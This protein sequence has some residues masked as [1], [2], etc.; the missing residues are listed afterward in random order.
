MCSGSARGRPPSAPRRRTSSSPARRAIEQQRAAD[1]IDRTRARTDKS[2]R[3]LIS[4][5][6]PE[7]A[8]Q[9]TSSEV[10]VVPMRE[11]A[12]VPLHLLRIAIL[13]VC[14]CW[15]AN[16]P[17][18]S[19]IGACPQT[20]SDDIA[21]APPEHVGMRSGRLAEAIKSLRDKSRD[22]H[23]L[24]VWRNCRMVIELYAESVTRDHNHAVYSVTKSVLATLFG[25]LLKS[26]RLPS[27]DATVADIVAASAALDADKLEKARRIRIRHAMSMASGLD[28][29]NDPAR[30]PIY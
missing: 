11:V 17:A 2:G 3:A 1:K 16:R 9:R 12:Q 20:A 15:P 26:G 4:G 10:G 30:H 13:V 6:R 25:V 21:A 24:V 7:A 27:L 14:V 29:H 18:L 8:E 19:Q 28:Y 5:V 22:I 23:A